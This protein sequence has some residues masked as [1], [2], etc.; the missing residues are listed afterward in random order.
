MQ[1]GRAEL[2]RLSRGLLHRLLQG[3]GVFVCVGVG[4]CSGFMLIYRNDC[5]GHQTNHSA[6]ILRRGFG[7]HLS[8]PL[9]RLFVLIV[10][11]T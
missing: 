3:L 11:G 7:L 5:A 2:C 9:F 8:E 6:E 4:L 10:H 1:S